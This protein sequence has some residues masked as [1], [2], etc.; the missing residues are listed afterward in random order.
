MEKQDNRKLGWL[1]GSGR[2]RVV[3]AVVLAAIFVG[4]V[5]FIDFGGKKKAEEAGEVTE[6]QGKITEQT[7][8][9]PA[10]AEDEELLERVKKIAA[11]G[12]AKAL[13]ALY[14][15]A[16][17]KDRKLIAEYLAN[18]GSR[19]ML[20]TLKK[21]K[22]ANEG[23]V[24]A[25]E[26]KEADKK[27]EVE[28]KP[29]EEKP[30]DETPVEGMLVFKTVD[31]GSSAPLEG[32]VLYT[33][34]G[35]Y[36]TDGQGCALIAVSD[37]KPMYMWVVTLK[38][39]YVSMRVLFGREMGTEVPPSYTLKIQRGT[40]IGGTI[41]NEEGS[42]IK[43][44]QVSLCNQGRWGKEEPYIRE[45]QLKTDASGR[46]VCDIMP[47]DL[48]GVM[49][50]LFH[51]DYI[52]DE[53]MGARPLPPTKELQNLTS[54]M[55]MTRGL[56]IRGRVLDEQGNPIS[57]AKV[58]K[59]TKREVTLF[60]NT[61]T[62]EEGRF[63]FGAT[64]GVETLTAKADGYAPQL[65]KVEVSEGMEEVE[66]RLSP[67][68]EIRA[69]VVDANNM[70]VKGAS[71][72]SVEWQ[73]IESFKVR[74]LTDE[75]GRFEWK[76]APADEVYF[77]ISKTGY[78]PVRRMAMKAGQE[79]YLITLYPMLDVRGKV[80][81][82]GTAE[83]IK[84]FELIPGYIWSE[85]Q[86]IQW[87]GGRSAKFTGGSYEQRFD[88]WDIKRCAIRIEAEGYKP[89]VSREFDI[90]EGKVTY[91]FRLLK[92]NRLTGI[93][94]LPGGGPAQ[95]ADVIIGKAPIHLNFQNTADA[96]KR[97]KVVKTGVDGRFSLPSQDESFVLAVVHEAGFAQV[98]SEQFNAQ[99]E[100][101]LQP[102]G[103]VEGTLWRGAVRGA[104]QRV[105][106]ISLGAGNVHFIQNNQ[107]ITDENGFFL[108]KR[109]AAE[110]VTISYGVETY[111]G[112]AN[113][114]SKRITVIA[115]ETSY[116]EL[117]KSGRTVTGQ[118]AVPAD[119]AEAV[120]W[121]YSDNW[122]ILK[123]TNPDEQN[124]GQDRYKFGLERDG[125]FKIQYVAAGRYLLRIGVYKPKFSG[126][127]VDMTQ[128]LGEVWYEFEMPAGDVNEPFNVGRL[129][130]K[131]I[132]PPKT[133]QDGNGV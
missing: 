13:S 52:P 101:F 100:I 66:F 88:S 103:S 7:K 72:E 94:Y 131:M 6:T 62:D 10:S 42:P 32:V 11:D 96:A 79:E 104:G 20:R 97:Y 21:P 39:G 24:A 89:A 54:V 51:S 120:D 16:G 93:V 130:L 81:D 35:R 123:P 106:L 57:G 122:L 26:Q 85:G 47:S 63:S 128:M 115:G 8:E 67:A 37:K 18:R 80:V 64:P 22:E 14:S 116:V 49:I 125:I 36:M 76:D 25:E 118:A 91:D 98:T 105:F 121:S 90:T 110:A 124:Q 9:R 111:D 38:K 56:L 65:K 129:V 70:P 12:D 83:P 28:A 31:A 78:V 133:E 53:K 95:N 41:Q 117:G 113:T 107:V 34:E 50:H 2:L 92:E 109:V 59:G 82:A 108:F 84:E 55:V 132:K 15:A 74:A 17:P 27:N 58:Y 86:E 46:W 68:T 43:D 4:A 40:P 19:E 87:I 71:I 5:V 48:S 112:R 60:L 45:Y 126:Y 61:L 30:A 114:Y 102:W 73:G 75:N 127:G 77:D 1:V 23:Q 33:Q 29:D 44:V 3:A 99:P 119:Y 69:R